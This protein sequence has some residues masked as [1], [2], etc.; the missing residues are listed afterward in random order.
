MQWILHILGA[1]ARGSR[2]PGRVAYANRVCRP[3]APTQ[4]RQGWLC[5]SRKKELK[6]YWCCLNRF[7]FPIETIPVVCL[8]HLLS[9]LDSKSRMLPCEFISF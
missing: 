2:C 7:C 1:V 5:R 3:R 8:F 9:L 4:E 6:C